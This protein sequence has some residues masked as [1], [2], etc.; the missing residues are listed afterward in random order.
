MNNRRARLAL[1]LLLSC[2]STFAALADYSCRDLYQSEESDFTKQV[3][4]APEKIYAILNQ[5]VTN[6]ACS[7]SNDAATCLQNLYYYDALAAFYFQQ[8]LSSSSVATKV[9]L[10]TNASLE[11]PTNTNATAVQPQ[12]PTDNNNLP[13]IIVAPP[14]S[15]TNNNDIYKNIRF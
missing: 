4:N 10:T 6:N 2:C 13:P 5:C 1:T 12:P 14:S 9:P 11:A 15:N 3:K 7:T 8:Q